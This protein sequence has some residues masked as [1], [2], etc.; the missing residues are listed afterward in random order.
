MQHAALETINGL[1]GQLC[2]TNGIDSGEISAVVA[3]ANTIMVH[4][5]L[6]LD[7]AR[8]C[9]EPYIPV[10]NNTGFLSAEDAGIEIFP[11][12]VF[13]CLPSVGS[14]V[15]GDVIAG[16]LVSEMHKRQEVSLLVDI[17][18]NGEIVLGNRDWLVA[19]AGIAGP[20]LE[21][22]VAASGMRA[23]RGA[24][25]KVSISQNGEVDYHVIGESCRRH[26][27]MGICGSG[28]VD[29]LAGMLL[30]GII[31]RSGR[32]VDS[33]RQSLI[34]VPASESI[35]GK[36]IVITQTDINNIMRT[37]GAVT[38]ASRCSWRASDVPWKRSVISLPQGHSAGIWRS[39]APSPLDSIRI[40]RER[41]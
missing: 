31:D 25:D 32:F 41:R 19:C 3:G 34:V 2:A 8:I 28:L 11:C 37:K 18:T 14:Y 30:S 13:Y 21:G 17:G 36:N 39:R 24:V 9:R 7:P 27:A 15:G 12:G 38:Q 26:G 40:C 1:I 22:G 4:L 20:A 29:C 33:S 5:L 35:N 10:L 16:I 6:G 23:E